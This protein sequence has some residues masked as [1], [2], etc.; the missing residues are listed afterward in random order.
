MKVKRF[1]EWDPRNGGIEYDGCCADID[2]EEWDRRM[3]DARPFPYK[4]LVSMIKK[5]YPDIYRDL[6]LNLPNPFDDDTYETDE[7]LV[8]THSATEYF[9]RKT[10]R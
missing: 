8:L 3:A 5:S 9:F 7:Y 6:C 10:G 1:G 4:R 2:S